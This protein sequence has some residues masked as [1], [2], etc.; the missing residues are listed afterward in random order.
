MMSLVPFL[1]DKAT[2]KPN[3]DLAEPHLRDKVLTVSAGLV[4]AIIR[5]PKIAVVRQLD[6]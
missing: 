4:A 3:G 2:S 1:L 6:F 5:R